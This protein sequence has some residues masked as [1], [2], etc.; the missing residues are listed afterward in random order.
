MIRTK[1]NKPRQSR[2]FYIVSAAIIWATPMSIF[3]C[4]LFWKLGAL[5]I[6]AAFL[7]ICMSVAV[8]FGVA[9]VLYEFVKAR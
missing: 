6:P 8:G 3:F 2:K 5:T 1:A 7:L 4:F 9:A